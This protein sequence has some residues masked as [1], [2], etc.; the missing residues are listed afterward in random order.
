MLCSIRNI[1]KLKLL[2]SFCMFDSYTI[3]VLFY[4]CV[5][6]AIFSMR[7]RTHDRSRIRF[8]STFPFVHFPF[9][10]LLDEVV[11]LQGQKSI[12]GNALCG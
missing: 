8:V 12:E 11:E 6:S 3:N 4:L 5:T 2:I 7:S 10:L 1:L 9:T